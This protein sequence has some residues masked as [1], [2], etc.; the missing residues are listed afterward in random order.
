MRFWRSSGVGI[1]FCATLGAANAQTLKTVKD[2]G[3]LVCGVSQGLIGFSAMDEKGKWSGLDVDFC[4]A[5]ASAVFNDPAK[6]EFVPLSTADRFEALKSGNIDVLSRNSTWAMGREL[7]F[8]V[9]FTGVSY[10]DGQ[11]LLVP[12]AQNRTSALELDGAKICVQAGT[13]SEANL[14]RLLCCERNEAR[15]VVVSSP[16]EAASAYQDGRCTGIS[17]DVST[18]L[19]APGNGKTRR[20][21]RAAGIISKEPLGP[22][23]RQEDM[24]WFNIVKWINFPC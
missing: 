22:E 13:T 11:G 18:A 14:S 24:Q 10:Y 15:T 12:K 21:S 17:S 20:S 1:I 6:V 9:V 4:R 8:G 5:I 19:G 16:A 3:A 7:D 23:V 2:R